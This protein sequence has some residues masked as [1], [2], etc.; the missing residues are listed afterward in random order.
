MVV[1]NISFLFVEDRLH[2]IIIDID[3]TVIFLKFRLTFFNGLKTLYQKSTFL[4]ICHIPIPLPKMI[5]PPLPHPP[6]EGKTIRQL[7]NRYSQLQIP[8]PSCFRTK[9]CKSEPTCSGSGFAKRPIIFSV[10][11]FKYTV[12]KLPHQFLIHEHLLMFI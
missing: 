1:C 9:C 6:N 3:A 8:P 7:C 2:F 11:F 4:P 10:Q 12:A 5:F